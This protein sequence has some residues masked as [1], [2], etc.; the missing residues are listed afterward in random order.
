MLEDSNVK[1]ILEI[2]QMIEVSR[3]Y[4]QMA[5][6]MDSNAELSKSAVQR[7]GRIQ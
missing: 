1:P 5:K 4:E 7:M 3:A 6:I 2:T